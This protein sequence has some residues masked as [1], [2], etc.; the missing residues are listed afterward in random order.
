VTEN[1]Y[2]TKHI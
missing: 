1:T 2:M